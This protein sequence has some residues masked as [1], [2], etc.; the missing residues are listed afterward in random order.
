MNKLESLFALNFIST[1]EK[2]FKFEVEYFQKSCKI[3]DAYKHLSLIG[4]FLKNF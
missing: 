4:S 1:Q 3:M 2:W